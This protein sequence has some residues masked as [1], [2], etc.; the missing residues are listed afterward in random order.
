MKILNICLFDKT[1]KDAIEIILNE[2][3]HSSRKNY[4]VSATGSHGLVFSRKNIYFKQILETFHLN[5]P[6]GMPSVWIGKLKGSNEMQRCYGPDFLKEAII[7]TKNKKINHFFCGGK[8]GVA[9]ELKRV[10]EKKFGNYNI[11]GT[12]S[13]P[14][15]EMTDNELKELAEKINKVNTNIVWIGLSTPKQEIFAYRLSK[16]TNVNFICTVGAA[17]DFHTG[18]VKQAPKW[19]Q[20]IGMEWFFRLL[21]EPKRLWKRYLEIVPLFIWYNLIEL[22]KGD[23]FK[24][25]TKEKFYV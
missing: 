8:E 11:V 13:P 12:Y 3:Y 5:L 14:F 19:I 24:T 16:F 25:E 22:I 2:I 20:R 10:C 21:M 15:R 6:D 18:K 7:E 17:F 23:F 1:I 9:E 4:L